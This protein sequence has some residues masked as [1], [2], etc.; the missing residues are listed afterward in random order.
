MSDFI[1]CN[2]EK[3]ELMD[4]SKEEKSI[5]SEEASNHE[6]DFE[7]LEG[8]GVDDEVD[9]DAF[10]EVS[11]DGTTAD[12][13]NNESSATEELLP[14]KCVSCD[15]FFAKRR[16]FDHHMKQVHERPGD[17]SP[18]QFDGFRRDKYGIYICDL[19]C[20]ESHTAISMK[21]HLSRQHKNKPAVIEEEENTININDDNDCEN[22]PELEQDPIGELEPIP[23]DDE[24]Q[25]EGNKR[26]TM[27][28]KSRRI[29]SSKSQPMQQQQNN[30]KSDDSED[31]LFQDEFS[32]EV[33]SRPMFGYRCSYC[34]FGH[35][36]RNGMIAHLEQVHG[37]EWQTC[38][39]RRR[40][41]VRRYTGKE[42]SNIFACLYCEFAA[43]SRPTMSAHTRRKHNGF[44]QLYHLTMVSKAKPKKILHC[45][46]CDYST[47]CKCKMEM[48]VGRKHTTELKFPCH[49]CGKRFKVKVDLSAHIKMQHEQVQQ[50]CHVCGKVLGSANALHIHQKRE[51]FLPEFKCHLCTR[52]VVSQEN[53]DEHIQRAHE[54][55]P[56]Y[57]CELC[58]K[59][60]NQPSKLKQHMRTHTGERPHSCH[61]CGKAFARRSVYRQHMLIHTGKRPYVCD[62]CGKSFTQKPGLI[63][64]RKSHPGEKPPLPVVFI[65]N[66]LTEFISEEKQDNKQEEEVIEEQV[67]Y[68]Y[69]MEV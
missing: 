40:E 47:D 59:V 58:G 49:Y 64:H 20:F 43:T 9:D 10:E 19:C 18:C 15:M 32:N 5:K 39:E 17:N 28:G 16:Q 29:R 42:K 55:A 60:F 23:E 63:C 33:R 68:E 11:I 69:I 62:I 3:L 34:D 52:R 14:F 38:V 45:D 8:D 1:K 61:L 53:L 57:Q 65:E 31:E 27:F 26:S 41:E 54:N 22:Q 2:D 30:K 44:I 13:L 50:I 36:Q 56:K 7:P 37:D 4:I 48:H 46:K 6:S 51:H 12:P 66:I 35:K 25:E 24:A 21:F 67:D